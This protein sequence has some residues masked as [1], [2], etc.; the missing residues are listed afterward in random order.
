MLFSPFGNIW[1]RAWELEAS[2][3]EHFVSVLWRARERKE[4]P[5]DNERQTKP[6]LVHVNSSILVWD[7]CI[8]YCNWDFLHNV[9][10]K[11]H[12]NKSNSAQISCN[13][14]TISLLFARRRS[15]Y[16]CT[17]PLR[18]LI[19]KRFGFGLL[20]LRGCCVLLLG[21]LSKFVIERMWM[22]ADT[23]VW[24]RILWN[25]CKSLIG[26]PSL[27]QKP[28]FTANFRDLIGLIWIHIYQIV[29]TIFDTYSKQYYNY[30][31]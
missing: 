24:L 4:R 7:Y 12:V 19:V 23:H 8:I 21:F 27:P 25:S 15:P 11:S 5:C 2:H 30:L 16:Q 29:P 6:L 1:E 14:N 13:Q 26:L 20:I 10:F 22:H 9:I 28:N 3:K 18:Q 17:V 31:Q